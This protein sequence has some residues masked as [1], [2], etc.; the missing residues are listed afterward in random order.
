MVSKEFNM[1][2][3]T[4]ISGIPNPVG[5]F[6]S[7]AVRPVSLPREASQIAHTPESVFCARGI[8]RQQALQNLI[9]RKLSGGACVHRSG[10]LLEELRD[11]I[12]AA[13]RHKTSWAN[14][15]A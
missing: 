13:G 14:V 8:S 11:G 7:S 2:S 15:I 4:R 6:F 10:W 5:Q 9:A 1:A 12:V 3:S